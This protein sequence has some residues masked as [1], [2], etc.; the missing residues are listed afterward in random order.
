[1][2]C[3]FK[4]ISYP[5]VTHVF[6]LVYD[7]FSTDADLLICKHQGPT[8]CTR[9][10]EEGYYAAS[11]RDML[12]NIE[13]YSFELKYL[14]HVYALSFQGTYATFLDILL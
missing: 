4:K 12:Q 8:C 2:H 1:M 7:S 3:L 11:Q 5:Y 10:M 13:S 9:K 14:I 6:C